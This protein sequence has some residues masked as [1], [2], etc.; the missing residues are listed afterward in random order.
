MAMES[1]ARRYAR[2][3]FELALERGESLDDWLSDLRA[4]ETAFS[5][6]AVIPVLTAPQVPFE[7]KRELVDR[8]LSRVGELRRN[9]VYMLIESG[10]IEAIGAIV[11]ELQ[12]LVNQHKGIAEATVTTAVPISEQDAGRI[13]ERVGRLLGKKVIVERRVGPLIMGGAG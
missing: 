2:A 11:S 6:P 9:L 1:I 5:D 7:Q 13:A 3:V 4:I 10:R 8:G 12:R